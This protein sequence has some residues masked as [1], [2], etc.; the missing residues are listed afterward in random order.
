MPFKKCYAD[1]DLGHSLITS[2]AEA[3]TESNEVYM[4]KLALS[5]GRSTCQVLMRD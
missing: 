4:T 5:L 2:T 3:E 1:A